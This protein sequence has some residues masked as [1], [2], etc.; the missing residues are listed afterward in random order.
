MAWTTGA[1]KVEAFTRIA[2]NPPA[3]CSVTPDVAW[4]L[5]KRYTRMVRIRQIV[6]LPLAVWLAAPVFAAA[7]TEVQMRGGKVDLKTSGAPLSEVLDRLER[8]AGFKVERDGSPPNPLVPALEIKD[9]TPAQAV[10][11]VLE[12]LGMNY[13]L[14]LDDSGLRV[15]KLLLIG[16]TPTAVKSPAPSRPGGFQRVRPEPTPPEEPQ[17]DMLEDMS[18]VPEEIPDGAL[19]PELGQP[20]ERQPGEGYPSG[21]SPSGG[22]QPQPVPQKP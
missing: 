3:P 4:F 21:G 17:D 12:G 16:A 9:R 11:A 22:P 20:P 8:T 2:R 19:P 1:A 7:A 15:E 6:L 14:S 5:P 18:D 13:A 10:L